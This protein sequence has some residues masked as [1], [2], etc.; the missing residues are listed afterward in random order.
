MIYKFALQDKKH[1]ERY[2]FAIAINK[3][4]I[5]VAI[6]IYKATLRD[7]KFTCNSVTQNAARIARN[8]IKTKSEL[9]F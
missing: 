1:I 9:P 6:V 7:M 2:T 5:K 8:K 4:K 3:F